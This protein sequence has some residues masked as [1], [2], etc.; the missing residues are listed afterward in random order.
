MWNH[1]EASWIAWMLSPL[2]MWKYLGYAGTWALHPSISPHRSRFGMVLHV[3]AVI[4]RTVAARRCVFEIPSVCDSV[5][6][7]WRVPGAQR[8]R[9]SRSHPSL[10]LHQQ[11]LPSVSRLALAHQPVSATLCIEPIATQLRMCL[12]STCLITCA[13]R[14]IRRNSSSH[15]RTISR[16]LG[17][18]Q[19]CWLVIVLI[20]NHATMAIRRFPE[21]WATSKSSIDS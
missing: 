13:E 4:T 5:C 3:T 1:K 9:N 14:H 2:D 19:I 16:H 12:S 20:Q 10:A 18:P 8:R 6:D 11:V 7:A 17:Y 15:A 21:L